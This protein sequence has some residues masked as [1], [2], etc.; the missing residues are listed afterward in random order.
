MVCIN[1]FFKGVHINIP[2]FAETMDP[3]VAE[4]WSKSRGNKYQLCK[5][6]DL[7]TITP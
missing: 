3:F 2:V 7:H 1:T 5:E 4:A 6:S